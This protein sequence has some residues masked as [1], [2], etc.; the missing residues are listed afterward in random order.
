VPETMRDRYC[1][2]TIQTPIT[3][4]HR[5]DYEYLLSLWE[6]DS[7][8]LSVWQMRYLDLLGYH[9][10]DQPTSG[11]RSCADCD[12]MKP[13]GNPTYSIPFADIVLCECQG[14]TPVGQGPVC[15][16]EEFDPFPGE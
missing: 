6:T 9:G 1:N 15:P 10:V 13:F 11:W 7:D 12:G 2:L 4:Q 14:Y 16:I 3:D 5:Q 8:T